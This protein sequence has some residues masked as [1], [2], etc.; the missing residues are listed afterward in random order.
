MRQRVLL[1]EESDTIRNVA[2]SLLRQS[3]YELIAVPSGDKALEVLEFTRPDLIILSSDLKGRGNKPIYEFIQENQR[4]SNI[5]MLILSNQDETGLPFDE[6]KIIPKPFD[7]RDFTAK[8]NAYLGETVSAGE[9][10]EQVNPLDNMNDEDDFIDAALG[11]DSLEITGSED[12]NQT[13][14]TGFKKSNKPVEQMIGF[15]H[16]ESD[17]DITHSGKVESLIIR[18][19]KA[20]IKQNNEQ[21]SISPQKLGGTGKIE[22]L[23]DQFGLAEPSESDLNQQKQNADHDYNW[24]LNELKKEGD[25]DFK[26]D[27]VESSL[28]SDSQNLKFQD[29]SAMVDPIT[30]VIPDNKPQ[31]Q[32]SEGIDKFIDEFKKEVEKIETE[33]P[34]SITVNDDIQSDSAGKNNMKWEDSFEKLTT[35]NLELFSRQFISQLA[36]KVADRI[37][38]KI[39]S[40]KLLILIKNEI[41]KQINRD[42]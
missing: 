27:S 41:I 6:G 30:P 34:E 36:E 17:S 10:S 42:K 31:E 32:S 4:I 20:E 16:Q 25:S 3:G 2:E 15:D 26:P 28:M 18:D 39:D 33:L 37:S 5:P 9:S 21:Q 29:P 13:K 7:A 22:I 24:F 38:E 40:E 12:M 23:N 1:A 19:E 35:E 8:I 11:L 14:L